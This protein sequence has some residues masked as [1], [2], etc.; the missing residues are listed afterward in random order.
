MRFKRQF[1]GK[2]GFRRKRQ[3]YTWLPT[4]G[5]LASVEGSTYGI[6]YFSGVVETQVANQG[7][8]DLYVTPIVP[9]A[10]S[11]VDETS[12]QGL[13]LRD[14]TEGQDWILKRIVG[15][16]WV[17]VPALVKTIDTSPYI[18]TAAA[19]FFV[20]PADDANENVPLANNAEID[21]L[22]SRNV[23]QPWIWRRSWVLRNSG[24]PV[25][26]LGFPETWIPGSNNALGAL[27]SEDGPHIDSKVA[28]R[29]R[30]KERLWFVFNAYGKNKLSDDNDPGVYTTP[31][32]VEFSL[33]YRILGAMRRS[34]NKSTF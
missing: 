28:R 21:P 15:K 8:T 5:G 27:G 2:R 6:S 33:D 3:K 17:S 4:L 11:F 13:T 1:R 14:L 24:Q 20:G 26:T 23:R 22:N 10:T 9:D 25:P 12:E 31:A 7:P 19:G 29:I 32:P 16:V 30:R 18:I 34:S